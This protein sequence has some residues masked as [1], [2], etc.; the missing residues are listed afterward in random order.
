MKKL[1]FLELIEDHRNSKKEKKFEGTFLEYLQLVSD[2]PDLIQSSHKRLYNAIES[3]GVRNM[4]AA[5]ERTKKV[6][7]GDSIKVYD[8]FQDEFF[9]TFRRNLNFMK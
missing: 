2:N 4:S 7:D 6:F 5:D 3:Q 9:A 1:D 8:Y